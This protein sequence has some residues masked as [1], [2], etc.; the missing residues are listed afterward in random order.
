MLTVAGDPEV[1]DLMTEALDLA[2][3]RFDRV[4]GNEDICALLGLLG[5]YP[6]DGL[7]VGGELILDPLR[8]I[9]DARPVIGT[10][11]GVDPASLYQGS[12][13]RDDGR[14]AGQTAERGDDLGGKTH[15]SPRGT[16][17][18]AVPKPRREVTRA[19]QSGAV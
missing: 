3:E 4:P 2:G 13:G 11:S 18:P 14:E 1:A 9:R 15:D 8:R 6:A 17:A 10:N 7:A 19:S 5:L 12:D 16:C